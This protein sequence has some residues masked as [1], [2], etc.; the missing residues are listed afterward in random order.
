M[1]QSSSVEVDVSSNPVGLSSL[2]NSSSVESSSSVENSSSNIE[3]LDTDST[4]SNT[5]TAQSAKS[6]NATKQESIEQ[7]YKF[8]DELKPGDELDVMFNNYKKTNKMTLSEFTYIIKYCN[9]LQSTH[10]LVKATTL[11]IS[12]GFS[13]N[14]QYRISLKGVD[15]INA[16]M[17]IM[18]KRNNHII[19]VMLSQK[20]PFD[21]AIEIMKKVRS[22][23]I[24]D[25]DE[26]DIRFRVSSEQKVPMKE[27]SNLA[28]INGMEMNKISFRYKE[29]LSVTLLDNATVKVVLDCTRVKSSRTVK[30]LETGAVQYE[31]ELDIQK[32]TTND[33]KQYYPKIVSHIDAVKKA[34]QQANTIIDNNIIDA[35]RNEYM[36]CMYGTRVATGP[37]SS[38]SKQ[39]IYAMQPV[40]M[41]TQH[42]IKDLP[43]HYTVT[44]KAD[45]EY[46]AL[47]IY[48]EGVYL[49][50]T[51]LDITSTGVKVSK[52]YNGTILEGELIYISEKKKYAFLAFDALWYCGTDVRGTALLYDRL[53]HVNDLM[54]QCFHSTRVL[55]QY[56]GEFTATA[57]LKHHTAE[58]QSYF[59]NLDKCVNKCTDIAFVDKYFMFPTGAIK[60][61]VYLF[62][63]LM[64]E[65]Y[66]P[67]NVPY[68]LDGL[69]CTPLDQRY[70]KKRQDQKRAIYKWKPANMSSIDFW[71]ELDKDRLGNVVTYFDTTDPITN[72][73]PYCICTLH[74]G[75]SG[76]TASPER[77]VPF[78]PEQQLDKVYLP[79][80]NGQARDQS[81]I[82]I[83]DKTV[84]EFHYNHTS[85]HAKHA[86]V[87]MRT[88]HDKTESVQ[89]FQKK[90][91]NNQ[92]IAG[93]IWRSIQNNITMDDIIELA[94]T[95]YDAAV[96]RLEESL[97]KDI[98]YINR[99]Q[100]AYYQNN[101]RL[102]KP[103]RGW[104]N[105]ITS[106]LI[107]TYCSGR[108]VNGRHYKMRVLDM[109]V[110]RGGAND[111]YYQARVR[112][113]VGV[114]PDVHGL[115]L[116][117][118]CAVTRYKKLKSSKTAVPDMYYAV[119]DC[120]LPLDLESQKVSNELTPEDRKVLTK[121]FGKNES[122]KGTKFDVISSQFAIHYL[123]KHDTSLNN[124]CKNI[125]KYLDKDGYV[126]LTTFD[127]KRV[128]DLLHATG[129][130]TETFT[131]EDGEKKVLYDIVRKYDDTITDF[132]QTGIAVDIMNSWISDSFMTEYLVDKDHIIE[133]FAKQCNLK[134]IETELFENFYHTTKEF[135]GKVVDT[136]DN[137]KNKKFIIKV[138]AFLESTT[139]LDQKFKAYSNLSRFY[140][141]QK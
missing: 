30:N 139:A 134:C 56:T 67:A 96:K 112:Y 7:L 8:L 114:D 124:L 93:L 10:E 11:D 40:S 63:K 98:M 87:P 130:H 51:N 18:Y 129:R 55:K 91:G 133:T 29:R 33:A 99:N 118:D 75:T 76:N 126:I 22:A 103:W 79:I 105:Y 5:D 15:K 106:H 135:F 4:Q 1:Y 41:E 43:N 21:D 45:G 136:E 127:S 52:K 102:S 128:R 97:S 110:G 39:S 54:V 25:W 78:M 48:N 80:I 71:I 34:L 89:K 2:E 32:K 31:V 47:I 138:K 60:N 74:V 88:R 3:P 83:N 24:H 117:V 26:R 108:K 113:M 16:T 125:N 85:G 73:E 20:E 115:R 9:H 64:W 109:G 68:E 50:T 36:K 53:Q 120:S 14:Q 119:A 123:F 12:Y 19:F 13:E 6:T 44:E 35:V 70:T 100:D 86:W 111:K 77:P 59:D 65:Q 82:V 137:P 37:G 61:E 49:M 132:K 141:F 28:T 95:N 107:T 104:H 46:R 81:G 17:N 69:T 140:V 116:A 66:T 38:Q 62:C 92:H 57:V 101:D 23:N 58:I 84:V 72:G 42:L 90:Y 94:G 131:T 121:Y 27:K 122:A